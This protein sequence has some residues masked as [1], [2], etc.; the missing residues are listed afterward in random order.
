MAKTKQVSFNALKKIVKM[1]SK[2][3]K[4]VILFDT[5]DDEKIEVEVV[6]V[7]SPE[8]MTSFVMSVTETLF[9]GNTY[10][11]AIFELIYSQSILSYYTNVKV[12]DMKN[13]L[14]NDIVYSTDM[15]DRIIEVVDEKQ[16]SEIETAIESSINY[17]IKEI[18]SVNELANNQLSNMVQE[19]HESLKSE[20][21]TLIET[22]SQVGKTFE[23]IDQ[24]KLMSL[25]E[26]I[27]GKDE[28]KLVDNI[29]IY[30][31]KQEKLQPELEVADETM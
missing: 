11:P 19:E 10:N 28:K 14:I 3:D 1:Q 21:T 30:K 24:E 6:R 20:V 13:D 26:S 23:G 17:K 5:P 22:F 2:E 7:L 8:D 12:D 29:M 31:G 18:M 25:M 9:D 15:I 27:A 4:K 16:L